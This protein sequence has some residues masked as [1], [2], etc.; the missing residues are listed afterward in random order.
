LAREVGLTVNRFTAF[1]K[2]MLAD[3][4]RNVAGLEIALACERVSCSF[5]VVD[6]SV[7]RL[8]AFSGIQIRSSLPGAILGKHQWSARKHFALVAVFEIGLGAGVLHT[9]RSLVRFCQNSFRHTAFDKF[10]TYQ[11]KL[12]GHVVGKRI[13]K[14]RTTI[15]LQDTLPKNLCPL[16]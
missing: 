3:S 6:V 12:R 8:L 13:T 5:D 1:D 14:L 11:N 10:S 9:D 15:S 2:I 7:T 4:L 16:R